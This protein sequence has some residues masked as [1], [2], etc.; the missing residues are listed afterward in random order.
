VPTKKNLHQRLHLIVVGAVGECGAF[1][2][3]VC[4]P[5]AIICITAGQFALSSISLTRLIP[6][7]SSGASTPLSAASAASLRIADN[8][9]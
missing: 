1:F 9:Y 4:D 3:E 2:E 5:C 8:E 7:A 6:W